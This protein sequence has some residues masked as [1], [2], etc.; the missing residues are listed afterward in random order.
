MLGR[1]NEIDR[2]RELNTLYTMIANEKEKL[3]KLKGTLI[4]LLLWLQ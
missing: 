1:R 2:E 4:M 3:Q